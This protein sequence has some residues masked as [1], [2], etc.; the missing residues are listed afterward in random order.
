MEVSPISLKTL[1]EVNYGIVL[2]L[3]MHKGGIDFHM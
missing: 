2:Y 1:E 3:V